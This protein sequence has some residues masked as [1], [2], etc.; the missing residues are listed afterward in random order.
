MYSALAATPRRRNPSPPLIKND[1]EAYYSRCLVHDF[2]GLCGG[3]NDCD[4][5]LA[6]DDI[7]EIQ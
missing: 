4:A 5:A 7:G 2:S 3:R 6:Y 1:D